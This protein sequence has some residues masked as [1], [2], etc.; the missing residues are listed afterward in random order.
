MAGGPYE[1]R[2]VNPVEALV[3]TLCGLPEAALRVAYTRSLF[4]D[5]LDAE[6]EDLTALAS[7]LD[8]VCARAEQADLPAREALLSI[9]FALQDAAC[10]EVVVRLR[11]EA[12]E[13]ALLALERLVRLPVSTL[14]QRDVPVPDEDRVPD[15]GRGRPLTL[16]ERKAL[17]RRPQR[18]ALERLLR[19]PH[20]DVIRQL[21]ANP[22]VTEDDVLSI[23]A[24]RPCRPD[25]LTE[26]ARSVR[27]A[28][29]PRIRV[30]L[31]LNPDTPLEVA[32]PLTGL[33]LRHELRLVVT[34]T[35][36]AAPVRALCFE[37]LERRPP[38]RGEG[39]P[40]ADEILQ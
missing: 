23:A 34:S 3:R 27:W 7:A 8:G 12:A 33:L 1:R 37:H 38:G 31:V 10:A 40:D 20:P 5:A 13:G 17:A 15:Y 18:D 16:G 14:P 36:V 32:S 28:S 2:A 39:D 25:V 6:G 26:I 4:L 35:T 22:R 11:A 9:S 30:A 29:R 21:L 19:D 24:R